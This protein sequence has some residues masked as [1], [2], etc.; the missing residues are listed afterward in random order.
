[1]AEYPELSFRKPYTLLAQTPMIHFQPHASGVALRASEVKPKL[2][3]YLRKQ[4]GKEVP[5]GWKI[6]EQPNALNYKMRITAVGPDKCGGL[7]VKD[8][9]S[10]FGNMG[11]AESKDL[12]FRDCLLEITCFVPELLAF[13]DANIGSFFVLHN[14][15]TRQSKGFGG[16]LVK[17]KTSEAKAEQIIRKNCC[18]YFS[19]EFP[20]GTDLRGKL[21]HAMVVYA[22]LKNGIAM[23]EHKFSGYA[24]TEYMLEDV[25]NDKEFIRDYLI[26]RKQP[27]Y[28]SY[29]FIRAV[30]G[31]AENYDYR[32]NGLVK[33]IQ[34]Q[35]TVIENECPRI[36][37][38]SL[39]KALGIKRFHSPILIKIFKGKM[40]FLLQED[41]NLILGKV[42]ILMKDSDWKPIQ[43]KIKKKQF[44]DAQQDI[45]NCAKAIATP[46]T[47]DAA[48]FMNDFVDYFNEEKYRLRRCPRDWKPSAELTL[49]KG[50]RG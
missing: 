32:Q 14:F 24:T 39:E 19:A 23:G 12:V 3:R 26:K 35:D 34:Y 1:M 27:A 28:R 33:V 41:Y 47:F 11:Q 4:Y 43:V 29:E 44:K 21:N 49:E 2:D 7:T 22:C 48:F 30:L 18:H 20:N 16:F 31:L 36:P 17:E 37:L 5:A 6:P 40:F 9:K 13:L 46:E 8:C 38:A 10:Y 15:G 45:Y 25:G 50:G 42:F